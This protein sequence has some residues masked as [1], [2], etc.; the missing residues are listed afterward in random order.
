MDPELIMDL[1]HSVSQSVTMAVNLSLPRF[2][3]LNYYQPVF[4]RK[5]LPHSAL[6][7]DEDIGELIEKFVVKLEKVHTIFFTEPKLYW[8]I[9][10]ESF[11]SNSIRTFLCI[12]FRD[13]RKDI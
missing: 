12:P 9:F 7:Y 13:I 5:L 8:A 4:R 2:G 11:S 1:S 6:L 10:E 3:W